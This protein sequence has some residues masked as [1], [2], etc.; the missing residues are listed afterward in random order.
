MFNYY[1]VYQ[2]MKLRQK[3]VEKNEQNAQGVGAF[4]KNTLFHKLVEKFRPIKKVTIVKTNCNS[5]CC[6]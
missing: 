3:E 2:L 1:E 6:C 5:V 4:Q